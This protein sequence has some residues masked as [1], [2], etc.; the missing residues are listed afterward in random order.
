MRWGSPLAQK[1]DDGTGLYVQGVRSLSPFRIAG[2]PEQTGDAEPAAEQ[3]H[4]MITA[5]TVYNRIAFA[6][7]SICTHQTYAVVYRFAR[8]QFEFTGSNGF[9]HHSAHLFA[10]AFQYAV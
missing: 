10:A 8:I 1:G 5:D 4:K 6:A 9:C 3:R 2:G 7:Q